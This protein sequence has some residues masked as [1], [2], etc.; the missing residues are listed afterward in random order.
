MIDILII[1]DH[2]LFL[3]GLTKIFEEVSE[4]NVLETYTDPNFALAGLNKHQ[5]TLI[6]LDINMPQMSGFDFVL[7]ARQQNTQLKFILLSMHDDAIRIQK[8]LS[9]NID[10]YLLKNTSPQELITAVKKV[11][12]GEKYYNE[13]LKN[14]ALNLA[15]S[16]DPVSSVRLTKRESEVLKLILDELTTKQIAE[17]LYISSNTVE[18]H[19]KNLFTKF[20]VKNLTGLVKKAI[21]SQYQTN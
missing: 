11:S 15:Q 21:T 5:P 18:V 20:D 9:L 13:E 7:K 19:R 8:A 4:V 10:G 3:D 2:K 1:D 12:T 17:E 14:I 6:L 16:S